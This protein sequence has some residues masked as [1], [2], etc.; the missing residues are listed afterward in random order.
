MTEQQV[1]LLVMLLV[2]DCL[3]LSILFSIVCKTSGFIVLY[4]CF[5]FQTAL[6]YLYHFSCIY[7]RQGVPQPGYQAI[8]YTWRDGLASGHSV[9]CGG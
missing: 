3:C 8:R 1:Y 9:P 7:S 2:V 6:T 4:P 5:P